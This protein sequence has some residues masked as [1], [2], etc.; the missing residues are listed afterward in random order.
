VASLAGQIGVRSD[1]FRDPTDPVEALADR[2]AEVASLIFFA[3][4]DEFGE[5]S[6]STRSTHRALAKALLRGVAAFIGCNEPALSEYLR[7][8]RSTVAAIDAVAAGYGLN[9]PLDEGDLA[10]AI[11]FHLGSETLADEEFGVLDT[12]L[13]SRHGDLVEY[14]SSRTVS[15]NG[16]ACPGYDWIRIHTTA[17]AEHTNAGAAAA[18]L[19]L[20]Y[21]AGRLKKEKVAHLMEEGFAGFCAV[22]AQFMEGFL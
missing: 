12:F 4:I 22:Q 1:L 13:K 2:S 18:R 3:A 21:Y 16:T 15:T 14:L 17:E 10:R 9:R 7:P 20:Q 5:R 19:A 11:G 8:D 6:L